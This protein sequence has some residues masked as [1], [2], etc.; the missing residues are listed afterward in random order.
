V[1]IK[2]G[3]FLTSL[4]GGEARASTTLLPVHN[5]YEAKWD[6]T[7]QPAFVFTRSPCDILAC[8]LA[9]VTKAFGDFTQSLHAIVGVMPLIWLLPPPSMSFPIH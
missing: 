9:V 3:E 2:L 8:R 6:Q 4:H 7:S 1:E 5:V